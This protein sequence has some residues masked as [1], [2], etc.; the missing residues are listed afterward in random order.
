MVSGLEHTFYIQDT[1]ARTLVGDILIPFAFD[2]TMCRK[3][4]EG[5]A[6]IVHLW[7]HEKALV[8]G[9]RDRRL[10]QAEL[11]MRWL[12]SQGYQ[13]GV[14]N[15][16]GAAVPLDPGVL[17]ISL[18]VPNSEGKPNFNVGFERM[19][20][21][22]TESLARFGTGLAQGEV[23]GS[24]CPGEYDLS[25]DGKKFCGISQRRQHK[26]YVVQ[27][28]IVVEGHAERRAQMVRMFYE[29]ASGEQL[30]E[31]ADGFL[32]KGVPSPSLDYPHIRQ[33]MMGSLVS[34]APGR[35][36]TVRT[37]AMAVQQT[38]LAWGGLAERHPQLSSMAE[39][40]QKAAELRTRYDN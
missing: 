9:L 11:G 1:S 29:M 14:R 4:G 25:I 8:L 40:Q 16:G 26:A 10:Q 23:V 20:Q 31:Y 34:L 22:I 32:V 36:I 19:R 37:F 2:E 35:G 18:I 13:V 7:R 30:E 38:L 28:F 17:N 12:S 3:V 21:L 33:G 27:A 24:Y 15:S 5:A 6:P 39:L